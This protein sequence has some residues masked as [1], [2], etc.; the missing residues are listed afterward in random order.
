VLPMPR[1]VPTARELL[2]TPPSDFERDRRTCAELVRRFSSVPARGAGP[3]HP[4][5][6]I[7]AWPEWGV[8]QWRH[9]DHHLRQFGV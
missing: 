1:N 9:L 6:G 7:L 4:L 3:S 2:A 5:F 8:L